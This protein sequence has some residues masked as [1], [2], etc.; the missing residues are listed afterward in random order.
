MITKKRII[1]LILR[2]TKEECEIKDLKGIAN[3]LT[4]QNL[5][6]G[7]AIQS[8][9]LEEVKEAYYRNELKILKTPSAGRHYRRQVAPKSN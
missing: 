9:T 7:D 8:V 3:N 2:S 6:V 4:F 5:L 1:E